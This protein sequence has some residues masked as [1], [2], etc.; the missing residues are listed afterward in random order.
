MGLGRRAR[1]AVPFW[2][3]KT[4]L[5]PSPGALERKDAGFLTI[6]ERDQKNLLRHGCDG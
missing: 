2:R 4:L 6:D 5:D 3:R 1:P